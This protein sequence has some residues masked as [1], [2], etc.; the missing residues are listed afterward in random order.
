MREGTLE[1]WMALEMARVQQ[2]LVAAPRPLGDLLMEDAP[3]ARTR[4]GDEHRFDPQVL[5]RFA[6]ALGPLAR[7]RLRLPA[8]FF[9]DKD[10]AQDAYLA[11][12]A[13]ADLLRALGEVPSSRRATGASGSATPAR[14][15]SPSAT[16]APSSSRTCSRRSSARGARKRDTLMSPPRAARPRPRRRV[17]PLRAHVHAAFSG[18]PSWINR[19]RTQVDVE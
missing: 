4:G 7:R 8:T 10:L 17:A 16:A 5:R 3:A 14:G 12:E 11:D 19:P 2:S 9:V 15:T 18:L 6:D 13:A 1:R